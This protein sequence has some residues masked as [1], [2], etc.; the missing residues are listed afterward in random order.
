MK[1]L[2]YRT[3]KYYFLLEKEDFSVEKSSFNKKLK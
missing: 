2:N 3:N 1:M